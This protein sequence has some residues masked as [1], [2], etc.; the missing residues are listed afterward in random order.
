LAEKRERCNWGRHRL[1]DFGVVGDVF[2]TTK[3]REEDNSEILREKGRE[4]E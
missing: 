4:C 2:K 1:P 3:K